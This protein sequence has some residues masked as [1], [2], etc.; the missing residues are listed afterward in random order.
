MPKYW[1]SFKE[2]LGFFTEN[3]IFFTENLMPLDSKFE[4]FGSVL[5]KIEKSEFIVNKS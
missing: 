4:N 1:A 5:Q 3:L 2:N